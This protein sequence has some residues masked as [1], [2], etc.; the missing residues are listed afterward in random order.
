MSAPFEPLRERL[1]RAGIAPRHVRRYLRELTEHLADLTER[2]RAAGY[3]EENAAIRA[4]A[5]LG[6]DAELAVAME[7][8]PGFRSLVARFPWLVFGIAPTFL[9]TLAYVLT[10]L[11]IVA[12]AWVGGLLDGGGGLA[13]AP[14]WFQLYGLAVAQTA[15]FLMPLLIASLLVMLAARQRMR[16]LWPLLGIAMIV[17]CGLRMNANMVQPGQHGYSIGL[18]TT[19]L[20]LPHALG[21][22]GFH[23]EG[24][25]VLAQGILALLPLA[26]LLWTRRKAAA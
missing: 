19:I 24:L 3:D 16:L 12:T 14:F 23:F 21:G 22:P 17:T 26:W 20:P 11:L 13:A 5:L 7:E 15:T 6:D 10:A 9:A 4:R 8:Q 18:G 2:Q 25:I 1:L